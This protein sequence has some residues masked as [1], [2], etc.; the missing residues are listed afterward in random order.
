MVGKVSSLSSRFLA[1]VLTFGYD[2]CGPRKMATELGI[3]QLGV[4][5][6]VFCAGCEGHSGEG[7]DCDEICKSY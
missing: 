7:A 2:A 3:D 6:V 5:M 4:P 1:L